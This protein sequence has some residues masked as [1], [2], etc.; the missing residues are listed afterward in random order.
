MIV[1]VEVEEEHDLETKS[2]NRFHPKWNKRE[3]DERR[4]DTLSI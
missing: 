3:W 1:I 2:L 4:G